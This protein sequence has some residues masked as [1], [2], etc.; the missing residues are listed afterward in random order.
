MS[1]NNVNLQGRIPFDLELKNGDDEKKAVI[2]FS[3]SVKRNYKPEGDQYYPED[4]IFCKAFGKKAL[5]IDKYFSKGSE[6]VISGNLRKDED[7]DK[8]GETVK[9]KLYVL[10]TDIYFSGSKIESDR[11]SEDAPA[12]KPSTSPKKN[13]APKKESLNPFG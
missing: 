6:A 9:G 1:L 4:L 13:S 10:V 8:D 3:F 5:F 11:S 2:M 12:K 7:Y